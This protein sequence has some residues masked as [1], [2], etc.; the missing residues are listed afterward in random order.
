[1]QDNYDKRNKKFNQNYNII[2]SIKEFIIKSLNYNINRYLRDQFNNS[3][4]DLIK[5]FERRIEKKIKKEIRK[6][7]KILLSK[8]IL[9][10]SIFI[11]SI[12]IFYGLIEIL[13]SLFN[14]PEILINICFG[15]LILI[16]G[17]IISKIIK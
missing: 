2:D 8:I 14:L 4:K 6:L 16:I 7:G 10:L 12:F 1:M 3:K 13:I 5:Y 11:G 9:F 17:V 15:F